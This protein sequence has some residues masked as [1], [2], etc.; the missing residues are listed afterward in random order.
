MGRLGIAKQI[1]ISVGLYKPARALHRT[2][3]RSERRQFRGRRFL[4]RQFLLSP[5]ILLSMSGPTLVVKQRYC[6]PSA[7]WL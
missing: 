5:A 4:L 1:A 2:V 7:Q 3:L 6:F